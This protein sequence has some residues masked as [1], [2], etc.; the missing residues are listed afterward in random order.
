MDD[1]QLISLDDIYQTLKNKSDKD[2]MN[3]IN[4]CIIEIKIT[5]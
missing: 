3:L 2:V 5:K 1:L 4:E